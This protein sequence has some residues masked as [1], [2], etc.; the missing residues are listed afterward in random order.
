MSN[1]KCQYCGRLLAGEICPA[2]GY[3]GNP[4]PVRVTTPA[5]ATAPEVITGTDNVKIVSAK[6][7]KDA[8]ISPHA[9]TSLCPTGAEMQWPV[10][11]PPTGWLIEDGSSKLIA[12]YPD[13]S[14]LLRSTYGGAD[15]THFYVPDMRGVVPV[16]YKS[17]DANFGTLGE[18]GGEKTHLLTVAEMPSHSHLAWNY[19]GSAEGVAR[20][21]PSTTPST[22]DCATSSTGGGG[23]HDNLQ[24]YRTRQFIIK[25]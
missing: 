12:D 7:L 15:A 2:H 6:A 13:L 18:T 4:I 16:G 14:A 24:P 10:A 3:V 8:G 21:S 23:S 1:A 22:H 25:T 9:A 20:R 17:G 19:L 11:T 5:V